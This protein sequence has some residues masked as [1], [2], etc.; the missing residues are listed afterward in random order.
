M[1]TLRCLHLPN[2]TLDRTGG[3]HSLAQPINVR[4]RPPVDH[5]EEED[6]WSVPREEVFDAPRGQS[7]DH[8]WANPSPLREQEAR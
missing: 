3:S 1:K 2:K 5:G 7:D 8:R 4:V 6:G